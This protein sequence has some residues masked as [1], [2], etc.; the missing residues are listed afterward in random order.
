M[1][2]KIKRNI[3]KGSAATSIGSMSSLFFQFFVVA[4][5]ARFVTKEEFGIY[6]LIIVVVNFFNLI[7][8]LGLELTLVKLIAG[9]KTEEK[10]NFLSP[11]LKL[12]FFALT[13]LSIVFFVGG[14]TI[15]HL[16]DDKLYN[17]IMYIPIIFFLANFRDL[18]YNL[19]QGLCYFKHYAIINVSSSLFRLV[20]LVTSSLFVKID[21]DILMYIEILSTL[22]PLVHQILVIPFKELTK[23]KPVRETYKTIANYSLPLYLTN[24]IVFFNG[25]AN[26]FIIGIYLS[27]VSIAS[28]DV[29]F[30][31]PQAIGALLKSFIIVYFPNLSK[32]FADGDKDTAVK[33]IGKSL[34]IFS[35][36]MLFIVLI[37]F[38]FREE[39]TVL[40]FSDKYLEASFALAVLIFNNYLRG[41]ADL[42]G[43]SFVPAGYPRVPTIV[44]A[45]T[46]VVGIISSLILI[47]K[48]G[49]I[50]GAYSMLIVNTVGSFI[51]YLFLRKYDMNPKISEFVYPFVLLVA[52]IGSYSLIGIESLIMKLIYT[53][54]A[55][56]LSWLFL[57]DFRNIIISGY[58]VLSGYFTKNKFG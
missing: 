24:L 57:D 4:L 15:L 30:K 38:L 9:R 21:L 3:L 36:V 41:T 10:Q 5:M 27:S 11:V 17:Y 47:P 48:L 55:L 34:N 56:L 54:L 22:M 28:F 39:I 19:L 42:M 35:I 25:R 8:G 29:A 32:L 33:L 2:N 26:I 44:N 45:I 6:A 37:A 18:F 52:L 51:Q 13:L 20:L 12:R 46:S 23:D 50:G 43:Y 16:F 7:G 14:K 1:D 31:I 58:K 49:F 40:V 53:I